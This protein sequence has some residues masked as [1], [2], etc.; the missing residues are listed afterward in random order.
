MF[1]RHYVFNTNVDK[2]VEK[3]YRRVP[4]YTSFNIL[5]LFAQLLCK[6]SSGQRELS[7]NALL[8]RVV[9]NLLKLLRIRRD[10]W[11]ATHH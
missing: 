9:C 7:A 3:F 8:Q 4:N 1:Q 2:F 10:R 5:L 6:S 11:Q